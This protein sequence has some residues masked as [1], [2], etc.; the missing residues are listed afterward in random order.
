MLLICS[1][2]CFFPFVSP[3]EERKVKA[4]DREY[5][6]KFQY[7]VRASSVVYCLYPMVGTVYATYFGDFSII[8]K[9]IKT[10]QLCFKDELK[11]V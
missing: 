8:C 5:N 7:A 1:V 3:E 10:K 9:W 6:E 2:V 4:N 11:S